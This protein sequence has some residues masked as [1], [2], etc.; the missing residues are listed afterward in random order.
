MFVHPEK[1]AQLLG[2]D[3]WLNPCCPTQTRLQEKPQGHKYGMLSQPEDSLAPAAEH[4]Q[5]C[6]VAS[7]RAQTD[8]RS[9]FL[10][11]VSSPLDHRARPL[12]SMPSCRELHVPDWALFPAVM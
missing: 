9:G 7:W 8:M 10:F 5:T 6:A 4:R 2:T 12:L 3:H 1:Q 11:A